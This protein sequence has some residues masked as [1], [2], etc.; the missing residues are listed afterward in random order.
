V[1][2]LGAECGGIQEGT[3]ACHKY[4][5]HVGEC[6]FRQSEEGGSE[7]GAWASLLCLDTVLWT[8]GATHTH[9]KKDRPHKQK[10]RDKP[11]QNHKSKRKQKSAAPKT[12]SA[13]HPSGGCLPCPSLMP[14]PISRSINDRRSIQ[15]FFKISKSHRGQIDPLLS[16]SRSLMLPRQSTPCLTLTRRGAPFERTNTA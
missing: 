15:R 16:L 5:L 1:W 14:S 11:K 6:C 13:C 12:N 3:R 10:T 9:E 4:R 2:G 8:A 7:A